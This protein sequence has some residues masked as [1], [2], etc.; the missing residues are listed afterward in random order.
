VRGYRNR[1]AA[2]VAVRRVQLVAIAGCSGSFGASRRHDSAGRP[3][4]PAH[5]L[6]EIILHTARIMAARTLGP[7]VTGHAA[8]T[9][10]RLADTLKLRGRPCRSVSEQPDVV[11]A[12]PGR[13]GS[14]GDLGRRC[15]YE[16]LLGWSLIGR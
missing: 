15:R 5:V 12:P 2:D 16:G 13:C 9:G 3:Q 7:E 10:G 11:W 6:A 4:W 1:D 8:L 14:Y